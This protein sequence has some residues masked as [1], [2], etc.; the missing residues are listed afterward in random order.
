[1]SHARP[2][3]GDWVGCKAGE[4]R[5]DAVVLELYS[6]WRHGDALEMIRMVRSSASAVELELLRRAAGEGVTAWWQTEE[7]GYVVIR[8]PD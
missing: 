5:P 1:M 3:A 7:D 2:R 8:P 6:L 4:S